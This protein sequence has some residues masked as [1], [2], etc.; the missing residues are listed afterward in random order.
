MEYGK[1]KAELIRIQIETKYGESLNIVVAYVTQK[2]KIG[3]NKN[4][5]NNKRYP[6]EF[7]KDY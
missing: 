3:V 2:V 5:K 6:R 1:G 7:R 4:M